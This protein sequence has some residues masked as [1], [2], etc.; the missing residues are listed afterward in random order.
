MRSIWLLPDRKQ[1]G[2][3]SALENGITHNLH[4]LIDLSILPPELIL[5]IPEELF[6]TKLEQDF[7][8]GQF[9][10]LTS[11]ERIFCISAPAGRD[12]S[13]RIVSISNLQI[14][15]RKEE[16]SLN[17]SVPSNTSEEDVK[18]IN[19]V[20]V[21]K[22]NDSFKKFE[23]INLMLDAVMAVKRARSFA[24]ETLIQSSNKPE[25]MPQKKKLISME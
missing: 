19:E 11:G 17:F 8:F 22:K 13:G 1:T 5:G 4:E 23:S 2:C 12:I 3:V 18:I 7:L 10:I 24:S 9:V 14:L 20:F 21:N 15:G 25:W 16:A 6:R